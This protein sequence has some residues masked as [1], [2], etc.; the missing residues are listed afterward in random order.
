MNALK[1]FRE[2]KQ[3]SQKQ[4]ADALGVQPT[5]ISR[6]ERGSRQISVDKAKKIAEF[7]GVEWTLLYNDIDNGSDT[8]R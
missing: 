1:R 6:Y 5:T 8:E 7:L 3:M 4:L 2:Q